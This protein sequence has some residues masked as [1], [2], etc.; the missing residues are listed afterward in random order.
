[1]NDTSQINEAF[2]LSKDYYYFIRDTINDYSKYI[3]Q[4][5][6]INI[7]ISKKLSQFQEKF[8]QNLLD[9][10][11]IKNKYKNIID[12]NNIYGITSII[13]KIIQNLIDNFNFISESLE[14][15]IKNVDN[16]LNEKINMEEKL[17]Y[18]SISNNLSKTYKS[19][20][21]NKNAFFTKMFNTED[22][23]YKYYCNKN[24][25][26]K[27]NSDEKNNISHNKN[28]SN[29]DKNETVITREQKEMAINDAK[30]IESQYISCF[31]SLKDLENSFDNV[32]KKLKTKYSIYCLN[33][34][35][36]LKNIIADMALILKNSFSLPL[37]K[38]ATMLE[39]L[40]EFNKKENLE[41]IINDSFKINKTIMKQKP[42]N[43]KMKIFCDSIK[44]NGN[45]NPKS[46]INFLEDGL[47]E[48]PYFDDYPA[49]NTV[50]IFYD[51]FNLVDKEYKLDFQIENEKIQTKKLSVKLLSYINKGKN[52]IKDTGNILLSKDEITKLKELLNAHYN[53]VIFL[54]DLNTFRAKGAYGIPKDI[55][56]FWNEL[57][58]LMT[59]TIAIDKDFHTAKNLII[60]SQTYY[61]LTDENYKYYMFE[62][63]KKNDIFRNYKFWEG[64]M[65]FS[66]DKEIIKTLQN[67]KRNGT[68]IKKTQ[69]ESDD[70][71]GRIVFAQLV[72]MSDN[73][74]NFNFDMKKLKELIKPIIKHYN[75]NEE[76]ITIIDDVIHKNK[77]RTSILLNE[78][79]KQFDPNDLYKN[80]DAFASINLN[81]NDE[82]NKIEKL[83]DIY[84][85]PNDEE[86][87][88]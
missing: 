8:G 55:F 58:D 9:K 76:S 14:P 67:D 26:D 84:N 61:Y 82:T 56:D 78:E 88:E 36:Q 71:Y 31:G 57:F 41:K 45:K 87:K 74:I 5:K 37:N 77:L 70:L 65:Y 1:M 40:N 60:L 10:E 19:L 23:I 11:K 50:K 3:K 13:P 62:I 66:I 30:K 51:S 12:I 54:Q 17:E 32:S 64:Y 22:I 59:K 16:I 35:N 53:R 81:N 18:D 33:L 24:K 79:I 38:T 25:L 44:I 29:K 85:N 7:G 21:K 52:E 42:K 27:N 6:I 75:L 39:K 28:I 2:D 20:E 43:Y 46:H 83:E 49:L 47:E 68:L 48:M 4:Y 69:K 63:L 34:T 73:M 86:K 72:S 15:I 80:F